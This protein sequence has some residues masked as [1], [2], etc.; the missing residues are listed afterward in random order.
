MEQFFLKVIAAA[1]HSWQSEKEKAMNELKVSIKEVIYAGDSE[2]DVQTAKN[3][4]IDCIGC[5]WGFRSKE[6]L[7]REGARYIIDVPKEILEIIG[8]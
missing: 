6:I 4:E 8:V 5:A 1:E 3:A 2:T 7:E